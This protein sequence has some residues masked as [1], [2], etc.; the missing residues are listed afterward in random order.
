VVVEPNTPLTYAGSQYL[1]TSGTLA[2]FVFLSLGTMACALM[3]FRRQELVLRQLTTRD[4]LTGWLNRRAL[5]DIASLEFER[6]VRTD[7]SL[8]VLMLDID[9][10][11]QVNDTYGHVCGDEVLKHVTRLSA[12]VMRGYDYLFRFGGEEF[13]VLLPGIED[14]AVKNLANRLRLKIQSCPLIFE[15]E[16]I[17]I[18]VSIGLTALQSQDADWRQLLKRAD[19]ALYYAKQAGRNSVGYHNGTHLAVID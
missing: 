17:P 6:S 7:A 12:E 4:P 18:T 9:H 8:I 11:K 1:Q 5:Q 15:A 19:A 2:I 16:E 14:I 10:F 3:V 13:I